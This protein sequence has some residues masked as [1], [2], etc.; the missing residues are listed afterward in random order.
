MVSTEHGLPDT[1]DLG[2]KLAGTNEID[3][4]TTQNVRWVAKLG[5]MTFSS[6]VVANGKI[7]IGS[8]DCDTL[9]AGDAKHRYNGLILCFDSATGK[10]L[11][12][13]IVP[14][15]KDLMGSD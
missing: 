11:W 3:P 8:S 12:Q 2:K 7:I 6:P 4:A 9:R 5:T 10:R 15:R 1:F 13:L 14:W